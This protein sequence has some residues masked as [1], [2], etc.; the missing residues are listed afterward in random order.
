MTIAKNTEPIS[1]S[2]IINGNKEIITAYPQTRFIDVLRDQ[3]NLTGTK[4]GCGEGECGACS[5]IIN[6]NLVNACLILFGQMLDDDEV[7]TIEGFKKKKRMHPIQKSFIDAGAVQCGMCTPGMIMA[8]YALLMKN[9]NPSECDIQ[10]A[11]AG[12][13][14]R[15]TGYQKISHAVQNAAQLAKKGKIRI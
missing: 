2:L 14:C 12:N 11:L 8:T 1:I 9:S 10:Y 3:L 7:I 13:L 5:I 4:E 6:D 15:C